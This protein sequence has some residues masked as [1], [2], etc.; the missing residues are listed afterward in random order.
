M[1]LEDMPDHQYTVMPLRNVC[2]FL[3]L[4]DAQCQW[5]F[6]IDIFPGKQAL[7]GQIIMLCCR[8]CDGDS[9][10]CVIVQEGVWR[11]T[12]VHAELPGFLQRFVSRIRTSAHP[13][14]ENFGQ[15]SFPSIRFR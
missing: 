12:S 3:A 13:K 2:Q 5:L 14:H 1:I 10:D 11:K 7:F 8:C 9:M 15:D 4:F 6:Y